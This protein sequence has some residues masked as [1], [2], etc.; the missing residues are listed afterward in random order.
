MFTIDSPDIVNLY[1]SFVREITKF[2]MVGTDFI[3]F[4]KYSLLEIDD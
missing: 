3:N 1:A 4:G 2:F